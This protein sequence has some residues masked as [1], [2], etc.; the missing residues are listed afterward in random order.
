MGDE[1]VV[2]SDAATRAEHRWNAFS[3]VFETSNLFLLYTSD[4]AFH[5]VPKRAF[6]SE[7]DVRSFREVVRRTIA[8]RPAPGF[9]VVQVAG[10][11]TG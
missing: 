9:P 4:H 8:D 11:P 10:G 5:M 7:E 2:I 6:G 1:S 3:H